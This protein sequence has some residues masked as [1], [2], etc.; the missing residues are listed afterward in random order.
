[1]I[2][3][4]KSRCDFCKSNDGNWNEQFIVRS[5][6]FNRTLKITLYGSN[7]TDKSRRSGELIGAG[8]LKLTELLSDPIAM[9]SISLGNGKDEDSSE[10]E[11]DS[12]TKE[13]TFGSSKCKANIRL[14]I[15]GVE[16]AAILS[17]SR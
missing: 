13:R 1:M 9:R 11:E 2:L 15:D 12:D 8:M 6:S 7:D 17:S 5:V 3:Q 16:L 4:S 10:A 14:A